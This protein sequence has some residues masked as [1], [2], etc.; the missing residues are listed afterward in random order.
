V[1]TGKCTA[2]QVD[3]LK[4]SSTLSKKIVYTILVKKVD[5]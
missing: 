5:P 4:H 2:D 3:L 1:T